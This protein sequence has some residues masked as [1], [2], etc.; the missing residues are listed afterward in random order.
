MY[1]RNPADVKTFGVSAT[2]VTSTRV[3]AEAI[4]VVVMSVFENL[5]A[6]KTLH[7]AFKVLGKEDMIVKGLSAPLHDGAKRYYREAGLM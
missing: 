6:F 2:V 4:Y 7:P 1:R 5:K 3:P